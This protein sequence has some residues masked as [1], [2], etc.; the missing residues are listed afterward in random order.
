MRKY[1]QVSETRD[2]TSVNLFSNSW[3]DVVSVRFVFHALAKFNGVSV[4]Q[5]LSN[6]EWGTGSIQSQQTDSTAVDQAL[7]TT[8]VIGF[9]RHNAHFSALDRK[10][11]V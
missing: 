7:T 11:V 4:G 6:F 2:D 5:Q 8:A 10:S 3:F 1:A 9:A